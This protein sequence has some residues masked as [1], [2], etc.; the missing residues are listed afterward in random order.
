[1]A[2]NDCTENHDARTLL[3][4]LIIIIMN[5]NENK[6]EKRT[7]NKSHVKISYML[8]SGKGFNIFVKVERF[9]LNNY[10]RLIP[11]FCSLNFFLFKIILHVS[12]ATCFFII[13]D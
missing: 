3:I 1:M 6:Y 9:C 12:T 5:Y 11:A 10:Y 2:L 4:Y 13:S 8:Y 7:S